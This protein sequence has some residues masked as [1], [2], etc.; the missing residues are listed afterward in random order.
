MFIIANK[1][2]PSR[3]PQ[4][5]HLG[6]LLFIIYVND[7][8]KSKALLHTNNTKSCGVRKEMHDAA[9]LQSDLDDFVNLCNNLFSN[10]NKNCVTNSCTRKKSESIQFVDRILIA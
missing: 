2:I 7:L 6:P 8:T 3:V 4:G 9:L 1:I 5:S 10:A